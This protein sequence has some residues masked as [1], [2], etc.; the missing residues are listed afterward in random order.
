MIAQGSREWLQRYNVNRLVPT[1]VSKESMK[2]KLNGDRRQHPCA[3]V[4]P[5]VAEFFACGQIRKISVSD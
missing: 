4:A 2:P 1:H 5:V 3:D